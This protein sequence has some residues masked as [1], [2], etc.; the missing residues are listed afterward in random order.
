MD[1]NPKDAAAL[2]EG[3]APLDLLELAA[4]E[5]ISRALATGR[6]KYGRRNFVV[7]PVRASVYGAAIRRHIGAWLKGEECAPDTGLN[8]L[9]HIG[10][11]VHVLL[12][13][14]DAGT[15]IDDLTPTVIEPT[16]AQDA[17]RE[18]TDSALRRVAVLAAPA[19]DLGADEPYVG[20]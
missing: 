1:L 9:A 13:A 16:K 5:Q 15:F 19:A 7:A 17:E 8:H 2:T 3:R 20:D 6:D 14:I 12:A 11:N 18:E 10:A 4:D